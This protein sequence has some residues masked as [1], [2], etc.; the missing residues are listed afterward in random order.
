MYY[1]FFILSLIVVI[2][3]VFAIGGDGMRKIMVAVYT[4]IL[5][6]L[7][8]N[9]V[10]PV[11]SED[12]GWVIG[13]LAYSIHVVP[14]VFIYGIISSVI[15]DR[16]SFKV[17][18]YS[19]VI[20]LALHILFGMAFILPYGV[21]IESIPFTQLTFSEIFFNYATLLFSIFAFIFFSI[22]YILKQKFKLRV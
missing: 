13:I 4:S 15:S 5:A 9:I 20:S 8:L 19:N 7:I 11:P 2:F 6:V 10:E 14:I 22:D 16:I 1:A 18:K 17:K 3:I 21:I 12:G